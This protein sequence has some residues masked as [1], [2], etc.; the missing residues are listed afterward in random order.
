[1]QFDSLSYYILNCGF[2]I[3]FVVL[4]VLTLFT[5]M[6]KFNEFKN[7]RKS[8]YIL[9]SGFML[10]AIYCVF[11]LCIPQEQH[12][13]YTLLGSYLCLFGVFVVDLHG[14]PNFDK[15]GL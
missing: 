1:M 13:Y 12:N 15:C 10:M 4:S 5:H 9:G 14:I 2:V 11:R 8:R 3:I 7:Y 6:P